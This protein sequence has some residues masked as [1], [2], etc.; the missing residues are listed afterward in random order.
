M[1][2]V[3]KCDADDDDMT[4]TIKMYIE[5]E[6]RLVTSDSSLPEHGRLTIDDEDFFI[7]HLSA[8]AHEFVLHLTTFVSLQKI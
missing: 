2:V 3:R 4:K 7:I 6:Y 5:Y 8:L 1:V